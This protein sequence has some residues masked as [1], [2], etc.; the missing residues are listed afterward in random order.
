MKF[1]VFSG[2]AVSL[3]AIGLILGLNLNGKDQKEMPKYFIIHGMLEHEGR[4][5]TQQSSNLIAINLGEQVG[6]TDLD[7]QIYEIK[8]QDPKNWVCVRIDGVEKIYRNAGTQYLDINRFNPDKI[9]VKQSDGS[10]GMPK[11]IISQDVISAL[12]GDLTDKNLVIFPEAFTETK[13]LSLSS[14]VF[15]GLSYILIYVHD[16]ENGN[17]FIYE[18]STEKTWITGHTL[19]EALM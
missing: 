5:Y 9:I 12:I 11:T 3:I 15:P 14:S 19:M 16:S 10:F 8:G 13:Q 2:I 4:S 1:L 18:Y 7:Q 6:I 17:C